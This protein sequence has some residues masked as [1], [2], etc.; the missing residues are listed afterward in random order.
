MN[1]C[2]SRA[3]EAG[4]NSFEADQ[5]QLVSKREEYEKLY[6][7]TASLFFNPLFGFPRIDLSK[8]TIV[9]SE[10]TENV[11]DSKRDNEALFE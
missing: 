9:T 8:Y 7:G 2:S 11:F 1:T 5:K 10:K 3:M 4:R 6:K